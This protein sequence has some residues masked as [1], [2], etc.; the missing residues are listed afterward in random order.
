MKAS[1]KSNLFIALI[2]FLS[3]MLIIIV[4]SYRSRPISTF[5]YASPIYPCVILDAGHGGFDGGA[6]SENGTAE[7]ALNLD[8]TLK[9]RDFLRF[10][11]ICSR[12]TREN[13]GSLGFDESK[14]MRENKNADILA[15]EKIAESYPECD[16]LSIHLNKFQQSKY[17]GAQVFSGL[18][19]EKSQILAQKLQSALLLIDKS[20]TRKA[21]LSSDKVYLMKNISSPAVTVECGFLSNPAEEK[22]L[23]TDEY[24]LKAAMAIAKGYIDYLGGS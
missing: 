22:L 4:T 20:N 24:R 16:F 21:A 8:I 19:N 6:V 2:A 5:S 7:K 12:L 14:S 13:D 11:G 17:R 23:L 18:K 9:T 1:V 10:L 3:A 15:R